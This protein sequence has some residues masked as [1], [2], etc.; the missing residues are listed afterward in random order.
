MQNSTQTK[1]RNGEIDLLK[2]VFSVIIVLFHTFHYN[3]IDGIRPFIGGNVA[4]EFF[5][6]VSGF[7]MAQS[8]SRVRLEQSGLGGETKNFMFRKIR[9]LF[10][11]FGIAW[12]IGF[13]V[14]QLAEE[15]VSIVS[16]IKDFLTGLWELFFLR[17]SG[18]TDFRANVV[19][20]YISAMLLAMLVL[21]PLLI[22]YKDTFFYIIAPCVSIFLLGYICK[23]VGHLGGPTK[24]DGF[25]FRGVLRAFAEL[26]LGCI[27]WKISQT[28]LRFQYTRLARTLFSIIELFGYAFCVYWMF[29]HKSSKMSFVLIMIMAICLT[30]TFSHVG[31]A[32]PLFD[33]GVCYLLGKISFALYIGHCYWIQTSETFFP[34][35][36]FEKRLPIIFGCIAVTVAVIMILSEAIRKIMPK[37]GQAFKGLMIQE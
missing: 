23:T 12:I 26:S 5:F 10:P 31:I 34:Q 25:Y 3:E 20:W 29:G 36:P 30:L 7:L 28:M 21:Y 15:S 8:A 13:I 33:N 35:L 6:L 18:L 17:M 2:F 24:W 9:G 32:A 37:C 11:E 27:L 1:K 14:M 4:V 22:K 19:T 16:I